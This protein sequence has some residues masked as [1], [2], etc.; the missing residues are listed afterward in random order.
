MIDSYLIYGC[1]F[2][3]KL[4]DIIN[5]TSSLPFFNRRIEELYGCSILEL[6]VPNNG[7]QYFVQICLEQSD[8]SLLMPEKLDKVDTDKFY[9]VLEMFDMEKIKPYLISSIYE[10]KTN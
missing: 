2:S 9:K 8:L 1:H 5:K 7:K 4:V 10:L 3:E 6:D